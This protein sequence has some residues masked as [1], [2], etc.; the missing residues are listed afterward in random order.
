MFIGHYAVAFGTKKAAP[1][2][3][4]GTLI[5]AAEFLDILWP[6]FL[7]LGIEHAQ[8]VQS[9]NPFFRLNFYDY[10]ISHSLVTSIGWSVAVG[11]IYYA[12]RKNRRGA[13]FVG[14]AVFSHWLLDFISHRPDLPILPGVPAL[15][16]LGLWNS[17]AGTI[18]VET[19]M[20]VAGI[21]FYLRATSTVDRI[22]VYGFWGLIAFL[23]AANI[24]NITSPPPPGI[25]QVAYAALSQFLLIAWGYW[26]DRH[27]RGRADK[28]ALSV[29]SGKH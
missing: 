27:R 24:A 9:V 10:P 12:V 16:G 21:I 3:S 8:I 20:F 14:I 28:P 29:A 25:Q 22:G 4:L 6:V 19:L 13:L 7:L 18:I 26:I 17:E 1:A 23:V 5:L 11:G 15:V 2:V